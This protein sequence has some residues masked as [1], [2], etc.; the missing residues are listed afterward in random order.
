MQWPLDA[1]FVTY[2]LLF[3]QTYWMF[4]LVL[5]KEKMVSNSSNYNTWSI[6]W[7][8]NANIIIKFQHLTRLLLLLLI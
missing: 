4:R 5:N 2:I 3:S 7:P 1:K 8:L 6:Y